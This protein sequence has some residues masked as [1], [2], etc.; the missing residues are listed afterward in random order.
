[1]NVRNLARAAL[2]AGGLALAGQATAQAAPPPPA[3][4]QPDPQVKATL[5]D[6]HVRNVSA[7]AAA[8]LAAQKAT[9]PSVKQFAA[10]TRADHVRLEGEL[11]TIAAERGI[12]LTPDAA[13]AQAPQVKAGLDRLQP[14]TGADFDRAF[15]DAAVAD[16]TKQVDDLKVLRDR[17]PGKDARLKKWL[18]DA[19]NVME[20]HRNQARVALKEVTTQQRQGRTPVK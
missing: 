1:M 13:V 7:V 5:E 6:I 8:D 10:K 11:R 2:A 20:E 17:T 4:G 9:S 15:V 12:Q 18:D 16:R 19:E 3:A 14:L